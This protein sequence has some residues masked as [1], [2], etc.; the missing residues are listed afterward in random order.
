VFVNGLTDRITIVPL[1]LF[2]RLTEST[3][4]MTSTLWGGALSSFEVMQGFDGRPLNKV[5]EF[6]TVGIP[7][8]DFVARLGLPQP[9][10]I[11][12]DVDGI[13][14]LILRGGTQVLKRVTAISVEINDAFAEQA[15]DARRSL[16]AAGL[17]LASKAHSQL[18]EDNP[19]FSGTFNQVWT[20]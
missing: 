16:Q 15:E 20:R 17:R 11:K 1:P 7:M 19:A 6:R 4:N 14:H 2:E 3:L 12:M 5:F 9:E 10:Y 18:M 8:D 13:E